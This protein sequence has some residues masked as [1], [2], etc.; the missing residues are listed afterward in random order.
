M[1][2]FANLLLLG[3]APGKTSFWDVES[4]VVYNVRVHVRS[5]IIWAES[6]EKVPSSMRKIMKLTSPC[7]CAKSHLGICSAFKHSVISNDSVSGRRRPWSDCA[8][9]QADLDF[10]CSHMSEDTFLR[11]ESYI[12]LLWIKS[13]LWS[14]NFKTSMV[15]SILFIFSG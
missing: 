1:L 15:E 14:N 12:L 2:K 3:K 10:R 13:S 11:G 9:A 4:T 6:S 8:D 5:W 7:T